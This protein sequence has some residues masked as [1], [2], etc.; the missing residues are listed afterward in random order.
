MNFRGL[1]TRGDNM[2]RAFEE[3]QADM[4]EAFDESLS[5]LDDLPPLKNESVPEENLAAGE[6]GAQPDETLPVGE[7]PEPVEPVAAAEDNPEPARRLTSHAQ[8]R[9]AALNSFDELYNDAQKH[10]QQINATLSEVTTSH[11]LTR[12]FFSILHADIHRA[13]DLELA[14]VGL[15]AEQKKLSEL[16]QDANRR[17]EE[18]ENALAALQQRE[19]SLV[20]DKE[21]LRAALAAAKL[22][23]VEAGNTNA[24][25]EAELG[26]LVKTL[27]A[28]TVEAERRAREN[29]ALREKHFN[30]S[31]DLDK[32]LTR[33]A[34]ARRKLDDVSA[35]HAN[36][37]ARNSELLGALGKSEKEV[38]QLRKSLEMAQVKQSEMAE[39][40]R[41]T[42][43]DR[44]AEVTRGLAEMRGLRSEIQGL[45]SRLELA[46]NEHGEA[47]NEIAKLKVQLSD[48]A[49]EKHVADERLAAL[50]KENEKDKMNLSTASANISQLSLQQA[51]EQMQLDI[52]KQ[53]CED[54]RAEIASL[55]ARI[56]ELLPF[57]RLYRVTKARQRD[58]V[59]VNGAADVTTGVVAEATR[60]ASR[61]ASGSGRRRAV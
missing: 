52:H 60:T 56:E 27:S 44:E 37:A 10:L 30:L 39:A 17:Q 38:L 11:R 6:D 1:I 23:L 13:N 51:T 21:A 46:A 47:S 7:L 48:V 8:S 5:D 59:N 50:M 4:A 42:E 32:A 33:E 20:Q 45:Q 28:R 55:N 57:E 41:L 29:E 43:A 12:E 14:N 49:A 26:D 53:E 18:R 22:E 40:A 61:R 54:L 31:I 2:D 36:E 3:L 16:L 35:I 58:A 19:T 9:L 25:S 15:I 24:R 34:E